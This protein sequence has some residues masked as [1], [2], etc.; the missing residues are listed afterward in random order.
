MLLKKKKQSIEQKAM[1]HTPQKG[2][3]EEETFK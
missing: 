1:G 3:S 2:L